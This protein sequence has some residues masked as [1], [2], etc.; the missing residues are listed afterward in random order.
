MVLFKLKLVEI[1]RY[2]V[3]KVKNNKKHIEKAIN[4]TVS[5]PFEA[6]ISLNIDVYAILEAKE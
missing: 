1:A 2:T 3:Y 4:G 5:P 6:K